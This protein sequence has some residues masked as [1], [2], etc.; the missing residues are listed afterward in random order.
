MPE[1][2]ADSSAPSPRSPA[3][4]TDELAP[5][6]ITGANRGVG[7]AAAR[8]VAQVGHSV[9]LLCRSERLGR[10]AAEKLVAPAGTRS[11]E[12]VSVDLASLDSVRR[13]AAA[14]AALGGPLAALVNNAA[15][16]PGARTESRDGFELQL[17]VNHLA[18]FLLSCLLMPAL[19][20]GSGAARVITVS[21]G[22]HHGP[23]FDFDDPNYRR[24]RYAPREAY[25]QSKLANVLFAKTLARRTG[26]QVRRASS[27]GASRSAPAPSSSAASPVVRPPAVQSLALGPGVYDTDLLKDYVAGGEPF[28]SSFPVAAPESAGPI[29]ADLAVGRPDEN[30]NGGYF[31]RGTP[32][33]PS[34]AA[35][36]EQDQ[37]RLWAWSAEVTG[38]PVIGPDGRAASPQPSR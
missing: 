37:E 3:E 22:A 24:K 26:S 7:F 12:V 14:V 23:A 11:H 38:A 9:V 6:A 10:E 28:G 1:R 2:P 5:V 33:A 16:L 36:D 31:D 8:E 27:P 34:P 20:R 17:A 25:Q 19:Q 18:H 30:L 32:A 29:V 4:P 21:S 35:E 13:A 15:V